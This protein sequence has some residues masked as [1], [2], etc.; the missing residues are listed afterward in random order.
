ME[1]IEILNQSLESGIAATNDKKS[2][3]RNQSS[4]IEMH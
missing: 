4:K 2:K 3:K 1:N